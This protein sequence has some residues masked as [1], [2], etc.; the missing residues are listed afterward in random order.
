MPDPPRSPSASTDIHIPAMASDPESGSGMDYRT[1]VRPALNP[2]RRPTRTRTH[3]PPPSPIKGGYQAILGSLI[4]HPCNRSNKSLEFD[5]S[6][7]KTARHHRCATR[8]C[9]GGPPRRSPRIVPLT[10]GNRATTGRQ[11][12]V[13]P[14]GTR[15]NQRTRTDV[16][17]TFPP[18]LPLP[19]GRPSR[20]R[21]FLYP[22]RIPH[23]RTDIEELAPASF[24]R[25]ATILD[26]PSSTA[27][28]G[29]HLDDLRHSLD[30]VDPDTRSA[31]GTRAGGP[32]RPLLYG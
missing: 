30:G 4:V 19:A 26:S 13:V 15:R 27:A 20:R 17:P 21:G 12:D 24:S 10:W 29:G 11:G 7:H 14:S 25:I 2:A 1:T 3:R 16:R 8:E 23:H 22:F 5:F 9:P 28:S 31:R 18:E 6:V 32:C